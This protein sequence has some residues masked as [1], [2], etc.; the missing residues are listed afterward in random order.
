MNLKTKLTEILSP[1][2]DKVAQD[3]EGIKSNL[4]MTKSLNV[5][6]H[7]VD[8][9]GATDVSDKLNELF[10][11]V[12]NEGYREV[13]FP[14]GKYKISKAIKV[15]CPEDASDSLIVRSKRTYGA[16]IIGNTDD[17]ST[18]TG[19]ELCSKDENVSSEIKKIFNITIEGFSFKPDNAESQGSTLINI[20]ADISQQLE[21]DNILIENIK[22]VGTK[23]HLSS[24]ISI[25]SR[26]DN[27]L[28]KNINVSNSGYSVNLGS[29]EGSNNKV[30]NVT[31]IN[32]NNGIASGG[33]VEWDNIKIH[34][35]NDADIASIT[36]PTFC[37]SKMN[38][39]KLTGRFNLASNLLFV[40]VPNSLE[41]SN[42][43]LDITHSS[44]AGEL[45]Q[46][47]K[48]LSF[49]YLY[50]PNNSKIEASVS[51]LKFANFNQNFGDLPKKD[52]FSWISPG[53]VSISPNAVQEF[54]NLKLFENLGSTD[55][56]SSNG[57]INRK[58]ES[59]AETKAKTRMFLGYDRSIV[60]TD[61]ASRDELADKEGGAIFF[62]AN[63]SP[64]KAI[65]DKDFGNYAAG[66][67]GDIYV[68]SDPMAT[69]HLGYVST[70][71]Y[72]FRTEYMADEDKPTSVT[73]NGD[74]TV[75]LVFAKFPVWSNGRLKGTPIFSGELNILGKGGFKILEANPT[76]KS[77]KIEIDSS[78]DANFISSLDDTKGKIYFLPKKPMNTM[79]VMTYETIP[80]IHSGPTENRP[81]VNVAVGQQYFD[82]TIGLQVVWNGTKW[83][84]NNVDI[85]AKLAEYVRKDSLVATD[86]SQTPA[87]VG[88]IG[89]SSAGTIHIAESTTGP[90]GWRVV[91][92]Q[93]NDHL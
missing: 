46:D 62:G 30:M 43:S 27:L 16:L 14:D 1:F 66:V 17:G 73:N 37:A 68:E 89:V 28:I 58:Y 6:A 88:Q 65:K 82:T 22:S 85:D 81:T 86:I 24:C 75:T 74:R 13:V 29:T 4:D 54:D 7:G 45:Y 90:E 40:T 12:I 18:N 78:H 87:F 11:K 41:I 76:D 36:A 49:I 56:Y 71:K 67:S 80:V 44:D 70:Y 91:M 83:I 19:F 34:F 50:S 33:P 53:T 52:I 64:A 10:L 55:E 57:F 51:N 21:F 47:G 38:D 35:D 15:Y 20:G 61:A 63:G 5:V 48:P 93:P 42:I 92:L 32:C 59:K 25:N 77:M 39:F 69:G 31:S 84:A 3:I 8:N 9:T 23:D 72:S 26:C 79:S 60:E 2:I